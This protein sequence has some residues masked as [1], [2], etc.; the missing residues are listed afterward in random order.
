M[1]K[2]R[3][4]FA[5]CAVSAALLGQNFLFSQNV[6]AAS[7]SMYPNVNSSAYNSNNIFTQCGFKGQCTWFTYG[8]ALEKLNMKL[9]SQFYGNAIDWWYSNIRSNTFSYGSEPQANSI[10]VWSGGSKGY[11][12]VGFVE[13]VVGDT[14]YYN[15]G[16]VE[17][18]GYYDGYVKTISKQAI[19]NRGNLFL[20][21]YIYLNGSSNSSNNNSNNDYTII[22]TS[23]VSCSSLNV[24]SNP[25]LSSAVIGGVSKNQ[26]ISI[27]S[28]SNGWSKIKYGSGIGYVSSQYLYDGNNTISSG[29]GGSSSNESVQPGFVKLSSSSSLLNVRSSANLSSSIIGSLKNGS[30]VSILGKTGSWYKIKYG[31]KV[32][33]VSS[34]YISSSNNSNSS[35]D[36][37]SSTSTGRGT[38]KLSSTSSS[39]NLR[40]TPSLS[41]KILG[42][43]SHGSSVDI[44]GKTGSWYKIKYGSKIGYVS[45]QFITTSNSSNSSGSSVTNQR[46]GTVYLSN[47]YSTLN[48]RKNAGTNSSVI[49]SLAYGS[50]VEILSSSGEWYKINFKNT[51]GYVYSKYIK[52]TAQKVVAFNQSATQDKKYGVNETKVTVNNKNAEVV[53]S[54]TENEKKLV[55]MK[56]EKEQERKKSYEPVQTKSTEEAQRKTAEEAQR[57]ATEEA[58]RKVA[59]EAQRKA[60]EEAQRKATEEAQRKAVEEAQRKEAEVEASESQSKGQSNVSEKAPTTHGDVISY[61]RQYLGTPY[62]WGGTSPNGFDCSG[63]VQYVYRN[64]A[65]ISLPRDTYGQIGAGSRVSQDQLQPGDL[66]FPDAGHVGIYIGGGQMIHAPKSGDVVKISSVWSFYAGVRIK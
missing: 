53:K 13:K 36:N 30:S 40:E 23:K 18:R 59:E 3:K 60:A 6:L 46:F 43:L 48:V 32:A 1:N 12:H 56:S 2:S 17:R 51:T 11:G 41:S 20:K 50:K 28:E 19:K 64:A 65:G 45:S 63:F 25:S 49:S 26:T 31:S 61:A 7:D 58:Q 24:R 42:G 5:T 47:K 62:V 66:V 27:I 37:N 38:V 21:G 15:E 4:A 54:N 34:N 29:N 10:V 57:K 14:I 35:S 55:T 22:K 44:L 39:L 33:Y 9:P 16:N 52:D 8:R